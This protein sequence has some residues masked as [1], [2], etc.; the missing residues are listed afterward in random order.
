MGKL[1]EFV[2]QA[3]AKVD[4]GAMK[5]Y[6]RFP[7]TGVMEDELIRLLTAKMAE[8]FLTVATDEFKRRLEDELLGD[9]PRKTCGKEKP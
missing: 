9:L 2:E 7:T 1:A 6:L 4:R 3:L 5:T 8:A